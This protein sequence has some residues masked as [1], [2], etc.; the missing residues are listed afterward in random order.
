LKHQLPSQ[1]SYATLL[2]FAMAIMLP[3]H[4]MGPSNPDVS[5]TRIKLPSELSMEDSQALK[6]SDTASGPTLPETLILIRCPD[7]SYHYAIVQ[8][9]FWDNEHLYIFDCCTQKTVLLNYSNTHLLKFIPQILYQPCL[10]M[11]RLAAFFN[12]ILSLAPQKRKPYLHGRIISTDSHIKVIGDLHGDPGA[13]RKII[14]ELYSEECIDKAGKLKENTYVLFLGDLTDRGRRGPEIWYRI[15]QL[16]AQNLTQVLLARGNHETIGF[17]TQ[18]F[19]DE[20]FSFVN[21]LKKLFPFDDEQIRTILTNIFDS[22]SHGILLG[23]DPQDSSARENTPYPFLFLCHAGFDYLVPLKRFMAQLTQKHKETGT[24]EQYYD[25][26]H[27]YPENSGFLWADLRA[28][29][30]QDEKAAIERSERGLYTYRYN[31]SEIQGI[32]DE[33]VSEDPR[34]PCF[35]AG[36]VRGHEHQEEAVVQLQETSPDRAHDWKPLE[37]QKL[38]FIKRG[39]VYTCTSSTKYLFDG[40]RRTAYL[41]IGFDKERRLWTLTPHIFT[42]QALT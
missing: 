34:H 40:P 13:L 39:S 18:F 1:L 7:G 6:L 8:C 21:Q 35:L 27:P 11:A 42:K 26:W 24:T 12:S 32:F 15:S 20:D 31:M 10:P 36:M 2:S 38:E 14:K 22:Q 30:T 33:H 4:A 5:D 9:L 16:L 25:F 19:P 28:N 23:T 17:A 37:D 41:D 29:R 3:L